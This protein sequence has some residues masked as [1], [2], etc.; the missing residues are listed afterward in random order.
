MRKKVLLKQEYQ[1]AHESETDNSSRIKGC[2]S[3]FP[4]RQLSSAKSDKVL[5]P[6]APSEECGSPVPRDGPAEHRVEG[7]HQHTLL[8][9]L[10]KQ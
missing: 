9:M 3:L 8:L 5:K 1:D 6:G 10:E 4:K 2:F 7:P